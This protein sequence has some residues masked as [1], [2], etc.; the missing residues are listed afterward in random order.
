MHLNSIA[1]S[2]AIMKLM[3]CLSDNKLAPYVETQMH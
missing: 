2:F 1:Q 3:K